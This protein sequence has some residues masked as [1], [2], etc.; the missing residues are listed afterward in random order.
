MKILLIRFSSIGDIVLTT[1][2]IR[3]TRARYPN[4][5]IHFATKHQFKSILENNPHL[6]KV[7]TLH[8]DIQPLALELIKERYDLVIDLHKNLR[9][10]YIGSLLRQVF[11]SNVR[12]LRFKKLNL[13]KWF[14]V[15]LKWNNMPD[16]SIVDRYF[17]AVLSEGITNDGQGM[18]YFIPEKDELKKDDLPMSHTHGFIVCSVGGQHETKKMPLSKWRE[19]CANIQYPLII[20]GGREDSAGGV[21]G[22]AI[23]A[24]RIYNPCGKFNL[25]ESADIIRRSK[26]V[27]THDTGMM[28]IAAAFKKK[29]I[30][31]WGSTVPEFGMFPYYGFNTIKRTISPQ[32]ILIQNKVSCQPCSKIGYKS[33]PKKHFNCMQGIDLQAIEQAV[34]NLLNDPAKK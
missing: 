33:C 31:I 24:V 12:I 5:E 21:Q 29:I 27:I 3:C 17:D 9:T 7:F 30:S 8:D 11:N 10:R 22:A 1:P 26:L 34:T 4:A 25:N 23:D 6:D 2:I 32:S 18:D 28:H 14:L 16:K 20:V 13:R 19:L 15:N